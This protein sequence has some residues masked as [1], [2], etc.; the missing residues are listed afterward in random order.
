M[1]MHVING[2]RCAG[3]LELVALRGVS[4]AVVSRIGKLASGRRAPL[5][6]VVQHYIERLAYSILRAR[7]GE[8]AAALSSADIPARQRINAWCSKSSTLPLL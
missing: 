6:D 2:T 7:G 8:T 4:Q 3:L 5:R 1:L